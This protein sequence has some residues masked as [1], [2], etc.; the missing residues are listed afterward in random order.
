M[1]LLKDTIEDSVDHVLN[2][3]DADPDYTQTYQPTYHDQ[4]ALGGALHEL[5]STEPATT[6][7][8]IETTLARLGMIAEGKGGPSVISRR[9]AQPIRLDIPIVEPVADILAERDIAIQQ[10]GED[11]FYIARDGAQAAKPRSNGPELQPDGSLLYPYLGDAINGE[12]LHERT[13]DP[14]RMVG[15]A[16]YARDL[17]AELDSASEAA[18]PLAHEA[19]LLPYEY[20]FVR[21][22]PTTGKQYLVSGELPWGGV[23]TNGLDS[24]PMQLLRDIVNPV[25]VKIGPKTR[26]GDIER[27][28]EHLNPERIPGRLTFMLR[29]GPGY[30]DV[31][32]GVLGEIKQFAPQSV[33][34]WDIHCITRPGEGGTKIRSVPEIISDIQDTARMCGAVGL[35]LHGV[36]LE[37]IGDDSR[38]ECVDRSDQLP[39]HPGGVDPQLNRRQ[40][41][42]VLSSIAS[43]LL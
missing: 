37:T 40:Y 2:R 13:P 19:L 3:L 43:A 17:R 4:R 15:M 30:E 16:T 34:N 7:A 23:R 21:R 35:K 10:L 5:H 26:P 24:G 31:Q 41:A 11:V 36:H 9:C 1:E 6:P 12:G 28:V 27:I 42:T 20:S 32:A 25:G 38:L 8:R 39:T 33:L 29:T 18:I 14:S 22:D